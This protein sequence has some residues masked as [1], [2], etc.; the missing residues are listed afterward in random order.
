MGELPQKNARLA[1]GLPANHTKPIAAKKRRERKRFL[2]LRAG[3]G[4]GEE[5][6]INRK[7]VRAYRSSS[8][9]STILKYPSPY[10]R[11]LCD[12]GQVRWLWQSET[13]RALL[14]WSINRGLLF[15]FWVML[16][17]HGCVAAKRSESTPRADDSAV[18]FFAPAF[19]SRRADGRKPN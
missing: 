6:G 14:H 19:S 4:R 15:R 10:A 2:P 5:S 9:K 3:E 11:R 8:N 12:C 18:Q 17:H 13:Q 1:K 7:V 16:R